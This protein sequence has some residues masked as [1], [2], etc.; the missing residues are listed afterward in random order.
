MI[1]AGFGGL[2]AAIRLAALGLHV[3]VVEKQAGPGGRAAVH[4]AAGFVFDLGPTVITAHPLLEDLF[5]VE[6]GRPRLE[7]RL[8]TGLEATH[9]HVRLAA[10]DPFYRVHFPD[11]TWF[12]YRQDRQALMEEV[13]RVSPAEVPGFLRFEE[14]ARAIFE[15]GFLRL[16]LTHFRS[17]WDLLRVTPQLVRLGALRPLWQLVRR[18]FRDPKLRQ[19]F[20]FET[21]LIGGDPRRVPAIYALIH[22][23]ERTWGVHYVR[24]GTGALVQALVR[25]LEQLG[26][27]VR[28]NAEVCRVS[29]E[30]G[31]VTG[32][33]LAG[34]S[35]L[36]AEVVVSNADPA[37][38][39]LDLVGAEHLPAPVRWRIRKL[40]PSPGVFVVYFGFRGPAGGP[41]LHHN[42]LLPEDY[43]GVLRQIFQE[44]RLPDR[45]ALY[46]HVPTL[47]D[48][49]LA[50]PGCHAA[51]ALALVP[52]WDGRVRWS[53][54]GPE[55]A[56]RVLARVEEAGLLPGV[57]E[58][59][60][61]VY[62]RTPEHFAE[63]LN[64]HLG[65]AFGPE[66]VLWQTASFRPRNRGEGVKGLYLVGAGCQPG[67]GV[68][69]VLM[70]A[71]IT[72]RLVAEDLG[73]QRTG[74]V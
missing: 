59:L 47:T 20:S 72:A 11:G 14:A 65:N 37:H 52:P 18:C 3:T 32:V 17:H 22:F 61:Y 63:E 6:P 40:R 53:L 58:R 13:R 29:V 73:L 38:T 19:V 27:E 21:L 33:R 69:G 49:S 46:L 39:Y 42:V 56:Q 5:R 45:L 43:E 57:R 7:P 74:G 34:G 16:G 31:R 71:K 67:A 15:Q 10:L 60:E 54:V 26:G 9:R 8:P 62:W 66:P 25:K 24:G 50:P 1:G 36:D 35:R 55:Y 51:Y 64:S 68:P 41:V 12:D 28:Y 48:P 2:A 30:D 23:V 4:R 44:R 70:S